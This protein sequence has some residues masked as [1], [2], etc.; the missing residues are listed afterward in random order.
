MQLPW[1]SIIGASFRIYFE[2]YFLAGKMQVSLQLPKQFGPEKQAGDNHELPLFG[3]DLQA[4]KSHEEAHEKCSCGICLPFHNHICSFSSSK[5]QLIMF[6]IDDSGTSQIKFIW[7]PGRNWFPELR[8][9]TSIQIAS[10]L[11]GKP[12]NKIPYTLRYNIRVCST[13][14]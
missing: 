3:E 12:S 6:V 13:P 8:S 4:K 11:L 14:A 7:Q 1:F 5:E 10:W 9:L 2:K